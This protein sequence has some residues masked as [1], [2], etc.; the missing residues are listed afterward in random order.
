MPEHTISKTTQ[1]YRKFEDTERLMIEVSLDNYE[2]MFNE[3]DPT[4]FKRRDID[5][6]LRTFF[7]ECSDEI[8]MKHSIA[9]VFYLP[10]GEVDMEKQEKCIEG[11]RNFFRFNHY[12]TVK[13]RKDSR[14]KALQHFIVGAIFLVIAVGFENFFEKNMLSSTLGQGLFIGGWVFLWEALSIVAFKNS[15]LKLN[16]RGWER[17]LDAPIVFK[18]ERR[19]AQVFE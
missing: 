9:V 12:L 2:D 13:E 14:K 11:L 19:P 16:L 6:H 5:P 7:E 3:W 4:P 18:K 10:K 8:S 15:E 1:I 17:F